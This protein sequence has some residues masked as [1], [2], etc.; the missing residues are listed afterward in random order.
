MFYYTKSCYKVSL[1]FTSVDSQRS[2]N[3]VQ[4]NFVQLV[5][6]TCLHELKLK[7]L[8]TVFSL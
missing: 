8:S 5:T 7:T 6:L 4:Y 1:S 2:Y 3:V